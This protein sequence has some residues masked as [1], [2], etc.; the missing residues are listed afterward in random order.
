MVR[1]FVHI[2]LLAVLVL[3]VRMSDADDSKIE[4]PTLWADPFAPILGKD[5][6]CCGY[7]LSEEFGFALRF[8]W[9]AEQDRFGLDDQ[10]DVIYTQEGWYIGSFPS[11]FIRSLTMEGS[12]VLSDGRVLNFDGRCRY[13]VGTCFET[14]NHRTHPY[15]RGA[16]R[17]PLVPF[18]SVAVD[19]ELIP[20]GEPLY[21]PELDGLVMPNGV[22]HDGCL[23]ADDTGSAI[24]RRK[25][26]FF[27]MTRD[28]F[29]TIVPTLAD[30]T[31]I[32]PHIE[33]PR[34]E[35]LRGQ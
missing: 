29:R 35:Y 8:Y 22:V 2:C 10:T 30:G 21:V 27:V 24:R 7:P 1:V 33:D 11:S 32:T 20:I 17:R 31:W 25:I 18:R 26:D 14:L 34:C 9:L 6:T 15:G 3:S 28:N 12:G 16:H 23:R 5:K 4:N 19:R 13:G